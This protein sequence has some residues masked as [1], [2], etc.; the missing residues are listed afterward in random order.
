MTY[1]DKSEL[2]KKINALNN[3]F[4]K[5][6]AKSEEKNILKHLLLKIM[7]KYQTFLSYGLKML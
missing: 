3:D 2:Y 4:K 6:R 5:L 7:L 1:T